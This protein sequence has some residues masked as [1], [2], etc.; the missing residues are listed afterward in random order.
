MKPHV[1]LIGLMGAGKSTVGRR[2]ARE[3]RLRFVDTD[4]AIVA[5]TGR[6]IADIFA[7]EGEP[8]FRA[9]EYVAVCA[10][11]AGEP[12]VV[13]L[14]GGAVTHAPT[15]ELT[16][17]VATRVYLEMQPRSVAGRLRRARTPRPLLGDEPTVE[18]ISGMLAARERFYRE[19][20]VTVSGDRRST[21]AIAREI[22]ERLHA[23]RLP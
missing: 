13:A 8:G 22:V 14:G 7:A 5:S 19:A 17:R 6:S 10:A 20:E 18:R 23:L 16:E 21:G 9:H 11:F 12:A 4:A 1:A 15:R 2:L 3:L